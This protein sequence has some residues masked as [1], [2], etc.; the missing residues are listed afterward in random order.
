MYHG[1]ELEPFWTATTAMKQHHS[2]AAAV[3]VALA[4]LV[5]DALTSMFPALLPM[6]ADRLEIASTTAALMVAMFSIS[7][8]LPQPIL[9]SF[10]DRI[11]APRAIAGGLVLSAALIAAIAFTTSAPMLAALLALGGIGSAT[12]HP[13]GVALAGRVAKNDRATAM[14]VFAAGGMIGAALGPIIVLAL[15]SSVGLRALAWLILPAAMMA[16]AVLRTTKSDQSTREVAADVVGTSVWSAE[17]MQLTFVGMLAALPFMT[18]VNSMPLWLVEV[19]GLSAQSPIIGYA[20]ATFS[21]AAA[22]GGIAAGIAARKIARVVVIAATLLTALPVVLLLLVS[23]PG[24]LTFF[25]SLAI[26]GGALYAHMPLLLATA[27]ERLPGRESAAGG[28]M[29]GVT[30]AGSGLLYVGI[31]WLQEVAGFTRAI[32]I[33][34]LALIPAAAVA[35]QAMAPKP[36]KQFV[37]VQMPCPCPA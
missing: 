4:H 11:G 6:L 29:I 31:G 30:W 13:A 25:F 24:S 10:A 22:V 14:G 37:P 32:T 12:V 16:A 36:R 17:M 18:L 7:T 28:M 1:A 33:A 15:A 5:N 20:L 3:T 8:S 21:G 27:Q 26:A 35:W 19:H 34:G 23:V 2:I 9:G